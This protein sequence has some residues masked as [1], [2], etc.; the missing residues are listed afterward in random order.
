MFARSSATARGE[1]A[2]PLAVAPN[3]LC[4]EQRC[5]LCFLKAVPLSPSVEWMEQVEH[6]HKLVLMFKDLLKLK[7][8][9]LMQEAWNL[10]RAR[11]DPSQHSR[12]HAYSLLWRP[13]AAGR[14]ITTRRVLALRLP[15][16][17]QVSDSL[18]TTLCVRF[19]TEIVACGCIYVAA[20]N[21]KVSPCP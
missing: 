9:D 12:L 5:Q 3:P 6:P 20:R 4:P 14:A 10:V 7:E 21:L 1:S 11:G 15:A 13:F 17:A 18:R 16:P 8:N 19:S 2:W